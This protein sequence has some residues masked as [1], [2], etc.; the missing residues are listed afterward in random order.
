MT[1]HACGGRLCRTNYVCPAHTCSRFPT[2]PSVAAPGDL[3]QGS[4]LNVVSRRPTLHSPLWKSRHP[5]THEWGSVTILQGGP[6]RPQQW[7]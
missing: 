1:L 2:G 6:Q 3:I 4:D 7:G 5:W